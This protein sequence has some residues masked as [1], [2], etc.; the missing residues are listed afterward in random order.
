MDWQLV[1]RY[2]TVKSTDFLTVKA[3][4]KDR[5]GHTD[6]NHAVQEYNRRVDKNAIRKFGFQ[7]NKP[8]REIRV[9]EMD[10]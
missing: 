2:F 8:S 6:N 7:G 3:I 9:R 5:C 4:V 1:A 10:D